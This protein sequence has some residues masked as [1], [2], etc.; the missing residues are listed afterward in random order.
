MAYSLIWLPT[1]LE[2]AGL[3]VAEVPGWERRGRGDVKETQGVLCHH[4]AGPKLGN[5]PSLNTLKLGRPTLVGPSR[6]SVSAA[7]ELTT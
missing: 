5:M 6:S 3:K 2:K 4:T 7:T 1:V